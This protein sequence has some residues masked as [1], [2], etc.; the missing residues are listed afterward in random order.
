MVWKP[1][2][3]G[4]PGGS[5]GGP[6]RQKI[7]REAFMRAIKR[8]E[9]TD[10]L[11]LEKLADRVLKAIEDGDISA[12]KEFGDRIDGK[13]SQP[14]GGADDLPPQKVEYDWSKLTD[15]QLKKL[16]ELKDILAAA[17]LTKSDA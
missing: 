3:S 17:A 9:S 5:P 4:N 13:V 7:W 16:R 1:G 11:A 15:E 10:P 8:R 6:Q 2:Q 14:I 12:A